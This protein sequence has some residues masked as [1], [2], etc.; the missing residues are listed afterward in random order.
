MPPEALTSAMRTHQKYFSLKDKKGKLTNKFIFVSNM[1]TDDDGAKI[2]DGNER[3]L[4]ARLS[5]TKF[6]WDQDLKSTLADH[7][8]ALDEIVFHAKLGTVGERVKRLEGHL[9]SF[10]AGETGADVEQAKLA[11]RLSKSDLVTGMVDEC[12]E[13]Q[14]LMGKYFALEEGFVWRSF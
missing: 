12:P 5:D 7:L 14:G 2:I 11:A 13:L 3:V 6:F 10:I 9:T 4:R 8:P 1:K